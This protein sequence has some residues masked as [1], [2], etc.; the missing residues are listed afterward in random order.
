MFN[1]DLVVVKSTVGAN[2]FPATIRS[3]SYIERKGQL[4]DVST[5]GGIRKFLLSGE[6]AFMFNQEQQHLVFKQTLNMRGRQVAT[7]LTM[8]LAPDAA[9]PNL[10]LKTFWRGD[11]VQATA[12]LLIPALSSHVRTAIADNLAFVD[13]SRVLYNVPIK[14]AGRHAQLA[15]VCKS[16][17]LHLYHDE[18]VIQMIH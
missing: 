10:F 14:N 3:R 1:P 16:K 6:P 13:V 2:P 17:G 4:I 15:E 8:R 12:G 9:A 18:L 5:Y 7:K 11:M